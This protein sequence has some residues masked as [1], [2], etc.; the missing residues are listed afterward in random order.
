MHLI[1]PKEVLLWR[2]YTMKTGMKT[3]VGYFIPFE[4]NLN[5]FLSL[6]EIW[7]EITNCHRSD[8]DYMHDICDGSFIRNQHL[9]QDHPRALQIV[10]YTDD[11]E[12]V[13]PIGSHTSKHKLTM[14]YFTLGNISPKYRSI[15]SA[16]QLIAVAKTRDL[17]S[18]AGALHKLLG[19][20]IQ[21]VNRMANTGI[22]LDLFGS[23]QTIY[24]TVVC[25]LCDSL[26]SSW[27]GGFKESSSFAYKGCRTCKASKT[28]M[29]SQSLNSIELRD[30][31]EHRDRC[32]LLEVLS[33]ASKK[34]WSKI[35][36]INNKSP[37]L[38][39][40][41][42]MLCSALVHDPMHIFMEGVIPYELSLVLFNIYVEHYFSLNLLNNKI[43]S[44][45]YK[46]LHKKDTTEI[47]DK[48][49]ILAGK[50]S[51]RRLRWWPY[52]ALCPSW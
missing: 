32:E 43:K 4:N 14:F 42:F 31:V 2:E 35:W 5:S 47:I 22:E 34:Y 50:S 8:N 7:R 36:G 41:D 12:I 3:H 37:L 16:I 13:N 11:I 19:D 20:F 46:Y 39:I 17:K 38:H 30:E 51:R 24:G 52:V 29:K 45:S 23:K 44:F 28:D 25:V 21:T 10:L 1:Q 26:A 15:L 9:F 6:P 27:L 40:S 33:P 49:H 18:N 48:C